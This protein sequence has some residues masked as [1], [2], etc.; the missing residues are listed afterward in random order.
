M[1]RLHSYNCSEENYSFDDSYRN[2]NQTVTYFYV[3]IYLHIVFKKL[4]IY[5]KQK[6]NT[7]VRRKII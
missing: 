5:D 4:K 3:K 7:N 6:K 2:Y 1:S